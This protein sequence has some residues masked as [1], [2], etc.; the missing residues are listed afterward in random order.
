MPK[1][2]LHIVPHDKDWAVRREGSTR[3]SSVH[4]TQK[5]AQDAARPTAERVGVEV[6]IHRKDGRIRDSESHGHDPNPPKDTR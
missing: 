2:D 3:A 4:P 6:V 5:E 1:R